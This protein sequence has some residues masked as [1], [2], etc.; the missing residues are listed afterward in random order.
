MSRKA[1]NSPTPEGISPQRGGRVP[2]AN[3]KMIA[4]R[5]S[6]YMAAVE[7]PSPRDAVAGDD[8]SLHSAG[9]ESQYQSKTGEATYNSSR[10]SSSSS[11]SYVAGG[12]R[13][14]P[15][16]QLPSDT[17]SPQQ[18][19]SPRVGG[20][21][22]GGSPH[23]SIATIAAA[24]QNFLDEHGVAVAPGTL[25]LPNA[26]LEAREDADEAGEAQ[27]GGTLL[28]SLERSV[29]AA[30]AWREKLVATRQELD[31][32]LLELARE[33]A[34][35]EEA[36]RERRAAHN[37]RDEA[38]AERD[39]ARARGSGAAS[40][41]NR[42]PRTQRQAV[43]EERA[44]E[45]RTR[46]ASSQAAER[47]A[48]Q[49][50]AELQGKLD[51]E[52][53]ARAEL[54]ATV[55]RL[56]AEADVTCRR[57]KEAARKHSEYRKS[58]ARKMGAVRSNLEVLMAE[59][60]AR[61]G[62]AE[63][64]Q[65]RIEE[66]EAAAEQAEQSQSAQAEQSQRVLARAEEE[67][68]EARA[69]IVRLREQNEVTLAEI[70]A[71][72]IAELQQLAERNGA[73]RAAVHGRVSA[74]TEEIHP[75]GLRAVSLGSPEREAAEG[76]TSHASSLSLSVLSANGSPEAQRHSTAKKELQIELE[77]VRIGKVRAEEALE[78]AERLIS[79]LEASRDESAM[80]HSA[81][82]ERDVQGDGMGHAVRAREDGGKR[83]AVPAAA[84]RSLGTLG[85]RSLLEVRKS[86][87]VGAPTVAQ[88]NAQ[89]AMLR[90]EADEAQKTGATIAAKHA[91]ALREAER[92]RAQLERAQGELAALRALRAT[93]TATPDAPGRTEGPAAVS[94]LERAVAGVRAL[95][96]R[97]TSTSSTAVSV[98]AAGAT[99]VHRGE[100][101]P[102]LQGKRG[103]AAGGSDA[104]R[105]LP[106]GGG[107]GAQVPKTPSQPRAIQ[108][109]AR[110]RA[111]RQSMLE[112]DGGALDAHAGDAHEEGAGDRE[113]GEARSAVRS[114]FDLEGSPSASPRRG[115]VSAAASLTASPRTHGA[116]GTPEGRLAAALRERGRME[117][118]L[119]AALERNRQLVD[120]AEAARE[121]LRESEEVAAASRSRS[122]SLQ[123]HTREHQAMAAKVESLEAELAHALEEAPRRA[124]AGAAEAG[125]LRATVAAAEDKLAVLAAKERLARKEKAEAEA[126]AER[127]R[128]EAEKLPAARKV[129]M[130]T[131]REA[132][133]LRAQVG[134]L[135]NA[136]R[137]MSSE[138]V[139]VAGDAR[140]EL[141]EVHPALQV[142]TDFEREDRRRLREAVSRLAGLA[143]ER[144]QEAEAAEQ[145]AREQI[146][147]A[148]RRA[149]AA[150]A[151]AEAAAA[152]LE[153]VKASGVASTAQANALEIS[154]ARQAQEALDELRRTH[155]DEVRRLA[156][157]M[158]QLRTQLQ[159]AQEGL[160]TAAAR[161]AQV[162]VS[163]P[164]SALM[165]A[166]REEAER[167]R[168]EETRLEAHSG[169]ETGSERQPGVSL[170]QENK[171]KNKR[172]RGLSSGNEALDEAELSGRGALAH[173]WA[174]FVGPGPSGPGAEA[175]PAGGLQ[176]AETGASGA[177]APGGEEWRVRAE[178]AE[179]RL[180]LEVVRV[181]RLEKALARVQAAARR[182]LEKGHLSRALD[183]L[184]LAC[185]E[186]RHPV[187]KE[188]AVR[189][190]EDMQSSLRRAASEWS[191]G[192]EGDDEM[193]VFQ[194]LE[195]L[196]AEVVT[197][198][199][200]TSAAEAAAEAKLAAAAG[201][202]DAAR[203]GER[204]AKAQVERLAAQLAALSGGTEG[205][206][207]QASRQSAVGA[208]RALT[209]VSL[210][211]TCVSLDKIEATLLEAE[212][213]CARH[214]GKVAAIERRCA[215]AEAAA[216]SER[217][218]AARLDEAVRFVQQ[219]VQA[220]QLRELH[221]VHTHVTSGPKIKKL[222]SR[223][224]SPAPVGI[225]HALA[226]PQNAEL[227]LRLAMQLSE[228]VDEERFKSEVAVDIAEAV[229]AP[230]EMVEVLGLREGSVVVDVQL[231]A[232]IGE[233]SALGGTALDVA[234]R[235]QK[236]SQDSSSALLRG[237]HTART[238]GLAVTEP[239]L[240][241]APSSLPAPP[242][243]DSFGAEEAG[244]WMV[245]IRVV[246]AEIEGLLQSAAGEDKDWTGDDGGDAR[247]YLQASAFPA[248]MSA[249]ALAAHGSTVDL[250][251]TGD[252]L[253]CTPQARSRGVTRR[254]VAG[255]WE[256]E[257]ALDSCA[258][259]AELRTP[260]AGR[261][262]LLALTIH[263]ERCASGGAQ[264]HV[265]LCR[266]TVP[267]AASEPG[268]AAAA[269]GGDLQWLRVR[270][271][272]GVLGAGRIQ[273]K[274]CYQYDAKTCSAA[275]SRR[276]APEEA[277]PFPLPRPQPSTGGVTASAGDSSGQSDEGWVCR[278]ASIQ[279]EN[280]ASVFAGGSGGAVVLCVS[281]LDP[282][283][284]GAAV[285]ELSPASDRWNERVLAHVSH[286]LGQEAGV[287][288]ASPRDEAKLPRSSAS[289]LGSVRSTRGA[290]ALL[291]HARS[292]ALRLDAAEGVVWQTAAS[293]SGQGPPT[294]AALRLQQDASCCT[295]RR[296]SSTGG[297]PR[298]PRTPGRE[299]GKPLEGKGAALLL[300]TVH[301]HEGV[302]ARWS[303]VA[304]ALVAV[305]VGSQG[306]H[307]G[308]MVSA[309]GAGGG[310]V[311]PGET[312][313][314]P[315]MVGVDASYLLE[316]RAAGGT[317]R[318]APDVPQVRIKPLTGVAQA[319]M[320]VRQLSR[321]G[322]EGA[323][324]FLSPRS[325]LLPP[326]GWAVS[327]R[328]LAARDVP[329]D[330]LGGGMGG[331]CWGAVVLGA[332]DKLESPGEWG[333][334][335]Q[336]SGGEVRRH[337]EG[338]RGDVEWGAARG[339]ELMLEQRR[340]GA[341]LD[342]RPLLL[343][344]TLRRSDG[345]LV[346]RAAL[347]VRP[348]SIAERWAVLENAEGR[349]LGREA[350]RRPATLRLLAAYSRPLAEGWLAGEESVPAEGALAL[351]VAAAP[352]DAAGKD[353]G[354][355][356]KS[357]LER[358]IEEAQ[359]AARELEAREQ[360]RTLAA[361]HAKGFG[362]FS[363]PDPD[364][365]GAGGTGPN[366][367]SSRRP[368]ITGP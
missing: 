6:A 242:R 88:L 275:A 359:L 226:T 111:L 364:A 363:P 219:Q 266:V 39:E 284:L 44:Q 180:G 16:L 9:D 341:V 67:A 220:L 335:A 179:E 188:Q 239:P 173:A 95:G 193:S 158:E 156:T 329:G 139:K 327:V 56:R 221:A 108:G 280:L 125:R 69:G 292:R 236:Q 118:A 18:P 309:D 252:E 298:T 261:P 4:E 126:E 287:D 124:E 86:T 267:C 135:R 117:K 351:A 227:E 229:R 1:S 34:R 206:A 92:L 105:G 322:D 265:L 303:C 32:A 104:R 172:Q 107:A 19:G 268:L 132:T 301:G 83:A 330:V 177:L 29:K 140:A 114:L 141:A 263:E 285:Q 215:D 110:V 308:V 321:G 231:D 271:A 362:G 339:Q 230:A 162:S 152:E 189:E 131:A 163:V 276:L 155:R 334:E 200:I 340:D 257:I 145:R 312:G 313:W 279:V 66:L 149:A 168:A 165:Q 251:S 233:A 137:A 13:R 57:E 225:S 258:G 164:G 218:R 3:S 122:G 234:F 154:T 323:S 89:V 143:D 352:T 350:E 365:S 153:V 100:Y 148:E 240:P 228:I 98:S 354:D 336:F 96:S 283:A 305:P 79:T 7:S 10:R 222:V 254:E 109:G 22:N 332:N 337:S 319:V 311:R 170:V 264:A 320:L 204:T 45:L 80:R 357:N 368:V 113:S 346:G 147:E 260:L 247:V 55:E 2:R 259:Q 144:A 101:S 295:S 54:G 306:V 35:R 191:S 142:A 11:L 47:A 366:P 75:L 208:E 245:R 31:T 61:D 171:S 58:I 63:Q 33:Q 53:A 205:S 134:A 297:W 269:G 36:E 256:E 182:R 190:G 289:S 106:R 349:V 273:L 345:A 314:R 214:T 12:V 187:L 60:E 50:A 326:G 317:W 81:L 328:V 274:L 331:L 175:L 160:D 181:V 250:M 116:S 316:A 120:E 243:L 176:T 183:D 207:S 277:R 129:T 201:E 166:A 23:A 211:E 203:E 151:A 159:A 157:E 64:L 28:E 278:V 288:A 30:E 20:P 43:L 87:G 27:T 150:A 51:A 210:T 76:E 41:E 272:E 325:P 185:G 197:L 209:E 161:A 360:T 26:E 342:G 353:A 299:E 127:L 115:S 48:I 71:E 128:P 293:S 358:E 343:V 281:C 103:L 85:R 97:T 40:G 25:P 196:K 344:V 146:A 237:K 294:L 5:I 102:Q 38:R 123:W 99:E 138:L 169:G 121:A 37:E 338:S 270:D 195:E 130:A 202:R 186:R 194:E 91:S 253:M 361:L 217:A 78:E 282:S 90:A 52:R 46:A 8:T 119:Q 199:D 136:V 93:P 21:S 84:R 367:A 167:L 310:S 77:R 348:G 255:G 224:P 14:S 178:I 184:M 49:R 73:E 15:P 355:R 59:R 42:T 192:Q 198:N 62:R 82:S 324:S 296:P 235:L 223:D 74:A 304:R 249:Q 356:R 241:D 94:L 133:V 318:S 238:I 290:L 112:S 248:G 300:V 347:A 262:L 72:H 246:A 315:C 333:E 212:K 244:R 70:A 17:S 174:R 286:V 232:R 65:R 68:A 24:R 302:S 213:H 291:P 216:Q 307:W